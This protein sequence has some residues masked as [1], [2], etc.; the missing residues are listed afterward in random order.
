MEIN[1]LLILLISVVVIMLVNVIIKTIDEKQL[2]ENVIDGVCEN[3]ENKNKS[4][5][6]YLQ[7]KNKISLIR[8]GVSAVILTIMLKYYLDRFSDSWPT[9]KPKLAGGE[10]GCTANKPEL[11]F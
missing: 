8:A 10:C 3:P 6:I 2:L 4:I 11:P 9:A 5:D 1:Y 7:K